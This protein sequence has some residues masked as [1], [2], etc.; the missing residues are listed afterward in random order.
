M[1]GTAFSKSSGSQVPR[2]VIAAPHGRSG[3][4]TVTI[5]LVAALATR[6][7]KVQPFKK[8]PDYIDPGWLGRAAG[9]AC[10]NLDRYF[11][12]ADEVAGAFQRGIRGA[13][14]AVIEGA[15]GLFDG[16][17]VAGSGSTAEI[18][19]VLGAPVILVVDAT[20]MT[21]SVAA[22]V[23]GFMDFDPQI[24]V[25]GVILNRVAGQRHGEIMQES[26]ARY[27]GLPVLGFV[28]KSRDLSIPD[29][30]LGLVPAVEAECGLQ[31]LEWA[32]TV[33]L[34]HLDLEAILAVARSAE[35]L[36]PAAGAAPG[37]EQRGGGG[38]RV[39]IGYLWDAAFSFY[40]PE[41]L[42]ALQAAGADLVP[43]S[44]L[45]D[46]GLPALDGL[47]L[48]GGFPE[49]FAASLEANSRLRNAVRQAAERGMP[50]YAEC[51]GLMYLSRSISYQG[52]DYA[53]AGVLPADVI[54]EAKPQGHG[55]TLMEVTGENPFFPIGS[56]IRGHEFH[57]S[58]L[59]N[60]DL[61]RVGFAYQVHKGNGVDH[62]HDGL[63]YRNVLAGYNHCH[64]AAVPGWAPA[65][66]ARA[67]EY[68]GASASAV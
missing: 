35:P 11:C 64:A 3:K 7:Y 26:I 38:P 63:V 29:R 57:N 24:R 62:K 17:D 33:A 59:A 39:R 2:V 67:A 58:R 19:R 12:T 22:L 68:R 47:Y 4:T 28:P 9:R 8:G 53:M 41:N 20:R 6:G 48:G 1:D 10:R 66:V 27:C 15:M 45:E 65:L 32:R 36:P 44:A 61:S 51:G 54:M 31:A 21:R 56:L 46:G 43:V 14:V 50:M 13:D 52:R 49:E 60:V 18:A 55:Y 30:H 40:Y 23:R 42:E 25:A 16:L 34:E 5:G 37:S